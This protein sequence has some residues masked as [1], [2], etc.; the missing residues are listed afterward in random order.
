MPVTNTLA[1][2][3]LVA[4]LLAGAAAL[5]VAAISAGGGPGDSAA[6]GPRLRVS[7]LEAG[8][9]EALTIA[10]E[11]CTIEAPDGT[12]AAKVWLTP[13]PG[14]VEWDPRFGEPV[15]VTIPDGEGSW[16]VTATVP[17]PPAE[18]RLEAACL[19]EADPP[20]GFVY[21]HELLV[22]DPAPAGPAPANSVS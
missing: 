8:P 13:A 20:H 2:K 4:A 14:T 7:T 19:D 21:R 3:L 1:T 12:T 22:S 5:G 15:A 11:G 6:D 16:S 18:Y 10:G 17:G 9:G